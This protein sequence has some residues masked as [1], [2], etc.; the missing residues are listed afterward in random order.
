MN[1][2]TRKTSAVPAKRPVPKGPKDLVGFG[3]AKV[4]DYK[5]L[6]GGQYLCRVNM[7]SR[8][9]TSRTSQTIFTTHVTVAKAYEDADGIAYGESG[10]RGN[11]EG[12]ETS[13][14]IFKNPTYPNYYYQDIK[15]LLG[16]CF[17]W[18]PNEVGVEHVQAATGRD[19]NDEDTGDQPC[20][21]MCL[22]IVAE[23][24]SYQDKKGKNKV[25]TKY[26]F[27][28]TLDPDTVLKE[29]GEA[30]YAELFPEGVV[31]NPPEEEESQDAEPAS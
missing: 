3:E 10:Y 12:E 13:I 16:A 29:L 5:N 19:E 22:L 30:K 8:S 7:M 31:Y 1:L 23:E 18:D 4:A 17:N 11:K 6:R 28:G 25:S 27:E 21:G 2:P 26:S 9:E 24:E 14:T 15:R 20:Q